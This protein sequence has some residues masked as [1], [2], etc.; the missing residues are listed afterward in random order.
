MLPALPMEA[1]GLRVLPYLGGLLVC[2]RIRERAVH[3][4]VSHVG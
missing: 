2:A 1:K 4:R 3:D